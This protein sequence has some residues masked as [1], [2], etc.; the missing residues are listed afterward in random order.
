MTDDATNRVVLVT[1][2]GKGIGRAIAERLAQNGVR[3]VVNNRARE[4]SDP[5][6][7]AVAAIRNGGGESVADLHDI[8]EADAAEQMVQRAIDTWGRLDGLV[9]NAGIAGSAQRF[10]SMPEQEFRRVFETN[11]F[12]NVRLAHVALPHLAKAPAGRLLAVASSAGL[13]GV[14]G[15][16]PYAASKG[17]LVAW[18]LSLAQETARET[19]RINVLAPYAATQ[20]TADSMKQNAA[21]IQRMTPERAAPVAAWLLSPQCTASGQIWVTGGGALR[22]AAVMESPGV[23]L[24]EEAIENWIAVNIERLQEMRGATSFA[25]AEAAFADFLKI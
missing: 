5:A 7:A 13:Y 10:S 2:A 8:T 22:R 4:G 9:L 11:F 21:L 17:A 18:A 6:A 19:L 12:A 1:G 16:S 24:P 20:M 3:V 15:R 23:R 25:G 14:Y